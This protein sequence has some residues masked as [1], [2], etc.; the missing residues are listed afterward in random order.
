DAITRT[1]ILPLLRLL[2]T[3][4]STPAIYTLSLHDALPISLA[5]GHHL[6]EEGAVLRQRRVRLG[7]DVLLLLERR[8]VGHLVGRLAVDHLPIRRLDEAV[9]VD[10]REGGERGDE[11]DVRTLG[12]LDRKSTRLNSS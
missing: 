10:P 2:A 7:D 9:L 6:L 5:T 3:A 4:P 8:V 11:T 12:R 1:C